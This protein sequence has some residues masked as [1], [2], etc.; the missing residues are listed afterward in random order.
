MPLDSHASR[1]LTRI[2]SRRERREKFLA[3]ISTLSETVE[4]KI[5]T[6][7]NEKQEAI[8]RSARILDVQLER[9]SQSHAPK[10]PH[11]DPDFT[12][13]RRARDTEFDTAELKRRMKEQELL[14]MNLEKSNCERD[15]SPIVKVDTSQ[16]PD[17][18]RDMGLPRNLIENSYDEVKDPLTGNGHARL[19]KPF[20]ETKSNEVIGPTKEVVGSDRGHRL[21]LA[22]QE[23]LLVKRIGKCLH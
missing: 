23:D 15:Q 10:P 21:W 13:N 16:V 18:K 17:R 12:T 6:N 20:I 2:S 19:D 4:S 3:T 9:L 14:F 11:M 1:S 5:A 7:E 8:H 22:E